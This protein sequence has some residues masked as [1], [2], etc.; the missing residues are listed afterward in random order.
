[1]TGAK[2]KY[3]SIITEAAESM[4]LHGFPRIFSS[5]QKCVKLLW[6]LA[7]LGS[8]GVL[9]YVIQSKVRDF[10][11]YEVYIRTETTVKK[12]LPFPAIA[13]CNTNRFSG[14][15]MPAFSMKNMTC[16]KSNND[17]SN[18]NNNNNSNMNNN[19]MNNNNMSNN[20]RSNSAEFQK[21][22]KMFLSG[23][24]D[25]LRFNAK[26]IPGFPASFTS[27]SAMTP[28][29]TFNQDGKLSQH[30]QGWGGLDMLL[31]SDPQDW[32]EL[33]SS[34]S[35]R[36]ADNRKSIIIYVHDPQ[37]ALS[38][39]P[40]SIAVTPGQSMDVILQHQ[41]IT[42]KT[43]PYPSKC[44]TSKTTLYKP[45]VPVRYTTSNCFQNC[46]QIK[47][48]K[49][50][51]ITANKNKTLSQEIC[52]DNF[53]TGYPIEKCNCPQPCYEILYPRQ[54]TT[55]IW[56]QNFQVK[57]LQEELSMFLNVSKDLVTEGFIKTRLSKVSIYYKEL[58]TQSISEVELVKVDDLLSDI[59]GLMG[60]F[61]GS[62]MLTLVEVLWFFGITLRRFCSR[63]E[64][65]P[66]NTVE[67]NERGNGVELQNGC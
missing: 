8:F 3:E 4:T 9:I 14:D 12:P 2:A 19:N 18:N 24:K 66:K 29:F 47:K 62:S 61:I 13:V 43:S 25:T 10:Y 5:K 22:C 44:H 40:S 20:N 59:G 54:I 23:M 34:N 37:T 15:V 36:F 31:F 32:T 46:L 57:Q 42:R 1:M 17:N 33:E 52:E 26:A 30:V 63:P 48:Q 7:F 56:P 6:L 11:K 45:V 58:T 39:D 65:E 50:C 16:I 35:S 53:M 55:S 41:I 27:T 21:A 38:Y 60:L 28:C 51:G 64:I 67:E 49:D